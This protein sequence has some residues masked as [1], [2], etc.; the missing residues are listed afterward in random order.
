MFP[1]VLASANGHQFTNG[2]AETCVERAFRLITSGDDV[3][4][5]LVEGVT[6]VELDP[7]ETSVG[8]GALPNADGVVELDASCMHGPRRRAG[9]VAALQGVVPAAAVAER[10]MNTTPHHL[11]A[12]HG[13]QAFARAHG[14]DVRSDLHS[15]RS[16]AL[17]KEWKRR[18]DA[19]AGAHD[20]AARW[21]VGYAVG[22]EM[23]REG[24]IDKNHVWGTINCLGL[25]ANGDL[26]GVTTTS[27]RA[28][29]IPGRVGDSPI[30]G[31][32]L[33][34]RQGAGA[35][36]ST[37]R[38]ESNLFALSSYFI[39]EELRRGRDPKD[40]GIA[41]LRRI[42]EDTIDPSLLNE[43]GEPNFNVKFYVLAATGQFSGVALY[44][45]ADVRFAVCTEHGA[46]LRTCEA[47]LLGS[48]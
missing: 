44:G 19:R 27:G 36:G 20:G 13:A 43:R 7:A 14:F 17:W 8:V 47:L 48:M 34:V 6:I 37:G 21:A 45:G 32:G 38:G 28:W 35:A 29:K 4:R 26:A 16:R 12:G 2:G 10:V 9:G 23:D 31:A 46:E 15:E 24:L 3:L 18:V 5:A 33:Y 1:V 22:D 41:A 11:I 40:A 25:S 42:Q 39:V 30:L